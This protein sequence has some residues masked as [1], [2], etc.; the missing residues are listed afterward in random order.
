MTS[1][2]KLEQASKLSEQAVELRSAAEVATPMQPLPEQGSAY[3]PVAE[4]SFGALS[5]ETQ[6]FSWKTKLTSA[7][8]HAAVIALLLIAFIPAIEK[9]PEPATHFMLV[10]PKLQPYRAKLV[11]QIHSRPA[12]IV[13]RVNLPTPLVAKAK[14]IQTVK[15]S[16]PPKVL[17]G[18]PAEHSSNLA[19]L[20]SPKVEPLPVPKPAVKEPP[21]PVLLGGFGDP[22]GAPVNAQTHSTPNLP[23]LGAFDA[24][25]GAQSGSAAGRRAVQAGGFGGVEGGAGAGLH[26][27]QG[28]GGVRTGGFGDGDG[29]AIAAG[30][31]HVTTNPSGLDT[32]V[33]ILFKPKPLYS[34]EA[35]ELK[36]EGRVAL[37]VILEASGNVRVLQ[38]VHALQ[39]GLDEAAEQAASQIRFRP[40]KKGGVA[41]DTRATLYITFQL[42]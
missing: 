35:R 41:V 38:V 15:I 25:A 13:K 34:A 7:A 37:D 31:G 1:L 27:G 8:I 6:E 16:E 18:L 4:F 33:E 10:A 24:A 21:K 17:P 42:T 23:R 30:R 39:H 14:P 11:R 40:A 36:I 19:K 29:P 22:N 2:R 9:L 32:P 26:S 5:L 3:I 28:A 20:E 12:Q